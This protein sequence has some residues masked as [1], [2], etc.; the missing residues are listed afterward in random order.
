MSLYVHVCVRVCVCTAC[1]LT[2]SYAT[3]RAKHHCTIHVA[4]M[5]PRVSA[6][7]FLPL[8]LFLM[9]SARVSVRARVHARIL[10]S[11]SSHVHVTPHVRLR[12]LAVSPPSSVNPPLQRHPEGLHYVRKTLLQ[13]RGGET[14]LQNR[15]RQP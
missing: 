14:L 7:C 11:V 8:S 9:K 1:M 4:R 12:T 10:S 6:F 15:G 2:S 13:S 3:M 5:R